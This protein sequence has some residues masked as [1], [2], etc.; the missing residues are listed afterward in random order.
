MRIRWKRVVLALM[1]IA[2]VMA[3]P[4]W[5][6]LINLDFYSEVRCIQQRP[7]GELVKAAGNACTTGTPPIVTLKGNEP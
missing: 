2:A 3:F 5:Y 7:N 4:Y 1:P 6:R